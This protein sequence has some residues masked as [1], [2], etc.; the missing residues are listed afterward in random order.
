MDIPVILPLMFLLAGGPASAAD[1]DAEE[2][3]AIPARI[4]A[5]AREYDSRLQ[6][7]VCYQVT[8]RSSDRSGSGE[9]WKNLDSYEHELTYFQ[10]KESYQLVKVNGKPA[11][12]GAGPKQGFYQTQ[13]QLADT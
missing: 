13:G 10:R 9:R 11:E 1:P 6:D 7:F 3:K 2:R 8:R 12:Q 5:Y 4:V